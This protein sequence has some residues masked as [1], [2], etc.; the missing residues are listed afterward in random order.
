MIFF[1]ALTNS[2]LNGKFIIKLI[3]LSLQIDKFNLTKVS[4]SYTSN[5]NSCS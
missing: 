5:S 3:S 4:G 1:N 2:S